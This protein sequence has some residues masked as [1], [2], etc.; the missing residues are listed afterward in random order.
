MR[1]IALVATLSALVSTAFLSTYA[2]AS[3]S[4]DIQRYKH[5]GCAI[6]G[7]EHYPPEYAQVG[8]RD[9]YW[10][11]GDS[12]DIDFEYKNCREVIRQAQDSCGLAV[13]YVGYLPPQDRQECNVQYRAEVPKCRAHYNR[14]YQVCET[15]KSSANREAK[16]TKDEVKEA[17][18]E[19]LLPDD[20]LGPGWEELESDELY[21]HTLLDRE[22]ERQEQGIKRRDGRL[23]DLDE[24]L[25][26]LAMQRRHTPEQDSEP[27]TPDEIDIEELMREVERNQRLD[28]LEDE[29]QRLQQRRN[30]I[31]ERERVARLQ[32]ERDNSEGIS[33]FLQ[34]LGTGVQLYNMFDQVSSSY[35]SHYQDS[36]PDYSPPD[37]AEYQRYLQQLRNSSSGQGNC[38]PADTACS[39][40]DP[41][42]RRDLPVCP[43]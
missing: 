33:T 3:S 4:L 37:D 35:D 40:N 7:N 13:E 8:L 2:H 28:E 16:Q 36:A 9:K 31:M 34:M 12:K 41:N 43:Y 14:Q 19:E 39:Y 21:D 5:R 24:A 42:C 15:I 30:E 10:Y 25:Q 17:V 26:R 38:V 27:M 20:S 32:R 11:S 22:L 6:H 29:L 18:W 23:N 1:H